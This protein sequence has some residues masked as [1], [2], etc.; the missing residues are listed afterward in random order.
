MPPSAIVSPPQENPHMSNLIPK[1]YRV[2]TYW[3]VLVNPYMCRMQSSLILNPSQT[4][5]AEQLQ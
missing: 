3:R 4:S 1:P 2:T 5:L